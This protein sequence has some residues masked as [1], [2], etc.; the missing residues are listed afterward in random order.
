[1]FKYNSS[2]LKKELQFAR[3]K[4]MVKLVSQTTQAAAY[5][6]KI[7]A[8]ND[9]ALQ[10]KWALTSIPSNSQVCILFIQ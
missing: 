2:K 5:K 1:M 10:S 9:L 8:F 4:L 6:E 3:E 7:A